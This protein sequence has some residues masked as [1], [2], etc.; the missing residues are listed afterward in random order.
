MIELIGCEVQGSATHSRLALLARL[1]LAPLSTWL[2][3]FITLSVCPL[4]V[5]TCTF[6]MGLYSSVQPILVPLW[7]WG[8]SGLQSYLLQNQ[9]WSTWNCCPVGSGQPINL[10][11]VLSPYLLCQICVSIICFFFPLFLPW[12]PNWQGPWSDNLT[13]MNFQ[14]LSCVPH[15]LV[16]L[17]RFGSHH[18][19]PYHLS[20]S[21]VSYLRLPPFLINSCCIE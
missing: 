11:P 17:A 3:P 16:C 5:P 8:P 4:L 6:P 2:A 20:L 21:F 10:F 9:G 18:S 19:L 14:T 15:Q 13:G 7:V 12:F 1:R